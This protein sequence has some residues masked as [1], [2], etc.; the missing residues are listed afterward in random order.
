MLLDVGDAIPITL[1]LEDGDGS[2]F[3][4]ARLYRPDGTVFATVDL[5]HVG[6]GY[7]DNLSQTFP[8]LDF[9]VAVHIVY[10]DA[11]HTVESIA[12]GRSLEVFR[13]SLDEG[14]PIPIALQL[15][16]GNA[17]Q[18]PQASLYLPDET[19]LATLDLTH[20]ADGYYNNLSQAYPTSTEFID[21]A[22]VIY[23][24]AGHT[25]ESTQYTRAQDVF[26]IDEA[27]STPGPTPDPVIVIERQQGAIGITVNQPF[28]GGVAISHELLEAVEISAI[29]LE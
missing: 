19:L 20:V 11:G 12:H 18:F 10:S 6:D 17:T 25:V 15:E 13:R 2:M 1:Q 24:D 23:E 21:V 14:D 4:R 28:A 16:D 26:S 22:Y 8:A 27:A 7:Y 5:D 9:L 3:P 29:V